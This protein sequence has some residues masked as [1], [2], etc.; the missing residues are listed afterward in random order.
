MASEQVASDVDREPGGT[1]LAMAGYWGPVTLYAVLIF[2]GSSISN[3]PEDI[4]SM[5]KVFSDKW[6]HFCEYGV[7]GALSY[8]ACRHAAGPWVARRALVVAVAGATL[9]GLSDEIHQLFVPFRDGNGWD[10]LADALG[11]WLGAWGWRWF[12]RRQPSASAS[13]LTA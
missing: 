11:A 12:E 6:L 7:L 5:L 2:W 3:P 9:Y 10:L 8:R 13:S 1:P 4:S